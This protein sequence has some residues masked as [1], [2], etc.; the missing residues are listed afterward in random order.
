MSD[1]AEALSEGLR[2]STTIERPGYVHI[3]CQREYDDLLRSISNTKK[4]SFDYETSDKG[5]VNYA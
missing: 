5:N 1:E 4:L 3:T 2:L